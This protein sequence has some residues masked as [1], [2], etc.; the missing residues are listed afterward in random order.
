MIFDQ[1]KLQLQLLDVLYFNDRASVAKTRARPFCALSLRIG[2]DTDI[3]LQTG[4]IHLGSHDLAFFPANTGYTR[5][6]RYDEMIVFHFNV[7]NF[8]GYELEILHDFEYDRLYEIFAAAY[9][10]WISKRSGYYYKAAAL[11]YQVFALIHE[12]LIKQSERF[13]PPVA[14]ALEYITQHYADY[15]LSISQ[16][17]ERAHMS[18]TYFRRLFRRDLGVSPKQYLNDLRLEHAQ[19]LLNAGYYTIADVAEMVGFRD[20]KNFATAF[21]KSFGYPPSAQTYAP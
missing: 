9:E 16:L 20:S 19:A 2:G 13:S 4:S 8:V 15:T 5:R 21:K 1:E 6:S 12:N 11:L 14:A 18:D 3:E 7:Q 17:A 10:E